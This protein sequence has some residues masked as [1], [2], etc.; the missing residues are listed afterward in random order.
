[1]IIWEKQRSVQSLFPHTLTIDQKSNEVH[2]AKTSFLTLKMTQTL[3]NQLLQVMKPGVFK[4]TL[5]EREKGRNGSVET[6]HKPR[7]QEEFHQKSKQC[8]LHFLI[9]RVLSI[10]NLPSEQTITGEYY[11]T[12]LKRLM[13]RIRRILPEYKDESSWCLL[14]DNAPSHTSL[15]VRRFLT[16]NSVCVLN[17][18]PY[19]PDLAPCDF[20][21]FQKLKMKLKGIYFQD[22]PTIQNYSTSVLVSIS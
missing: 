13:S 18:P 16:K 8:S 7:K 3:S 15:I 19:S 21:L 9:V 6:R 2:I 14:H 1:M 22:V 4:I 10:M 12:V 5:K 20:S 11:L 17:H